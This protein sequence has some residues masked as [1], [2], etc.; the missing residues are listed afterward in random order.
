MLAAAQWRAGMTETRFVPEMNTSLIA[1][2]DLNPQ[3]R[4]KRRPTPDDRILRRVTRI[5][6]VVVKN[7]IVLDIFG[8]GTIGQDIPQALIKASGHQPGILCSKVPY[9]LKDRF[10]RWITARH[11]KE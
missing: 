7:V 2:F 8:H 9:P 3:I 10:I 4:E 1:N 6:G 5:H 11:L